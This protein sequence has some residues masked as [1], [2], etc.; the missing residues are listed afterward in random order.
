MRT[1]RRWHAIPLGSH[2]IA[3]KVAGDNSDDEA[4]RGQ[5]LRSY[6]SS[7]VLRRRGQ[8]LRRTWRTAVQRVSF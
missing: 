2:A 7:E 4:N 8:G 1:L 6:L 5:A 3:C